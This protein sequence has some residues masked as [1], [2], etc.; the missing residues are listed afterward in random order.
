MT[1]MKT[2]TLSKSSVVFDQEAHT[3]H[4]DGV[5][6]SGVTGMLKQMLFADKYAGISEDVLAKAAQYGTSVHEGVEL[7]ETLGAD[8]G[9]TEVNNYR[10][11]KELA[12]LNF[13]ESE[14]LVSDNETIAS[15]IDLVF[16]DHD[17]GI[18]LA[19]IK[20]TYGGLDKEYLSWQLSVYAYLFEKANPD[21][22]V[23]GLL[24]IWLRHDEFKMDYITRRQD[25]DIERL[26]YEYAHGLECTLSKSGELPAGVH[27]LADAIAS[28][29]KQIKTITAQRDELKERM[30]QVMKENNCDKVDIDGKVL[31]TRVAATTRETFDGKS[32]KADNPELYAKYVKSSPV[33]ES[34]KITVRS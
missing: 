33:K 15:S 6:L 28:M 11:L 16:T 5:E 32:L 21:Y 9:S 2:L 26:I 13:E 18:W 25:S 23:K 14:Y 4:L 3:Y 12:G 20:T 24:G 8:D 27:G 7:F 19:D 10:K 1:D 30:L 22:K 34:L 17:G 29:E 31:I